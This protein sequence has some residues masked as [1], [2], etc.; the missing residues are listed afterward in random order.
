MASYRLDSCAGSYDVLVSSHPI[1][2]ASSG[3]CRL[4]SDG[5]DSDGGS[6][7]DQL[8]TPSLSED[9]QFSDVGEPASTEVSSI[10]ITACLGNGM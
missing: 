7:E 6:H 8:D 2:H 1:E 9:E 5:Q 3:D 4:A 10:T